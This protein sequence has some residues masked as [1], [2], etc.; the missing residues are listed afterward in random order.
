MWLI[1]RLKKREV[2]DIEDEEWIGG[3][4]FIEEVGRGGGVVEE[5]VI[6]EGD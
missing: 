4:D 6:M 2:V 5:C 3:W 1:N